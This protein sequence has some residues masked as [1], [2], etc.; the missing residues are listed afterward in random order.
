MDTTPRA[1]D[2]RRRV[3]TTVLVRGLGFLALWIVLMPSL[4]PADLAFGLVATV[5]ATWTSLRLLRPDA[6]HVRFGAL[7]ALAPH[8]LWQSVLAGLDVARR[9][10]DPRMPMDP[11]F[12]EFP[13]G[14]PRGLA[15]NVFAAIT[16]LLP[17]SVPV[18]EKR[19]ALVYHCLDRRL[20]NVEQLT[21]EERLF[22]RAL[23]P[24]RENDEETGGRT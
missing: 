18:G 17:G 7:L 5:L 10:F 19:D 21:H 8:F 22:A 15:R 12:V 4:K 3:P 2:R 11:G 1:P 13:V 23:V 20:P 16:S 14:F 9:A 6:G 24:A